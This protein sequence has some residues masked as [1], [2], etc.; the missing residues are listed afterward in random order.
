MEHR[1]KKHMEKRGNT[2]TSK[3]CLLDMFVKGGA[4]GKIVIK[5][6]LTIIGKTNT[7]ENVWETVD[8]VS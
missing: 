2:W 5:H 7:W 8:R 3:P 1:W 6:V 4:I